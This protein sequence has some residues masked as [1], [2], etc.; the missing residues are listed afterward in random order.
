M[1]KLLII[2]DEVKLRE[3]ISEIF[4]LFGFQV[5]E[6]KDGLDGLQKVKENQPHIILCDVNMPILDGY[7]FLETH[8]KSEFSNIPVLLISAKIEAADK[9]K[10]INLGAK[11]YI[12]KPFVFKELKQIVDFHLKKSN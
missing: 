5:F 11:S 2:D 4:T 9:E 1:Q 7:S 12:T 6:A 8:N 3:T 10:G